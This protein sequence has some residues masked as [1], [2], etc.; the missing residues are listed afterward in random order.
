MACSQLGSTPPKCAQRKRK[1][2]TLAR[3]ARRRARC[4]RLTVEELDQLLE[5][6]ERNLMQLR[7]QVLERHKAEAAGRAVAAAAE[8]TLCVVCMERPR[9]TVL[10]C[11]HVFCGDCSRPLH[12]CPA[13][14]QRVA[15][16]TRAFL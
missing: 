14:R 10:G 9:D 3:L 16:R 7:K 11:G 2:K 1:K 6:E 13:C 4:R 5:R 15:M 12:N 8:A